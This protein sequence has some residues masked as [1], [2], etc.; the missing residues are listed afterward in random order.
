MGGREVRG[1]RF[2]LPVALLVCAWMVSLDSTALAQDALICRKRDR[3]AT[4][5][6]HVFHLG[7]GDDHF[8]AGPG[9]DIVYGGPGNDVVNGGRGNDVVHG[10][11]GNDIACGGVG[12][13]KVD[14]EAGRDEVYGEEGNDVIAGGPG[15]DYIAGQAGSDV[16]VGFGRHRGKPVAHG[17]D[18]L[19]GSYRPD[20]LK[21]GGADTAYGGEGTDL[22]KSETPRLG[23]RRLDGG[24]DE[25]VLIGSNANDALLFDNQSRTLFRARGG[26]DTV[27]GSGSADRIYGGSGDDD[28]LGLNGSDLIFGDE[29][30]DF[31]SGNYDATIDA[32]C[33]R[34]GPYSGSDRDEGQ[35]R[36]NAAVAALHAVESRPGK[37][38]VEALRKQLARAPRSGPDL[39]LSADFASSR[40]ERSRLLDQIDDAEWSLRVVHVILSGRR[41][42]HEGRAVIGAQ[43][44]FVVNGVTGDILCQP[45]RGLQA[46]GC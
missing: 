25:D 18:F 46:N 6:A 29:G 7:R 31:C 33:E 40:G 15:D 3:Q 35:G 27:V 1:I 39:H 37:P 20:I 13:D 8:N 42:R 4:G 32:S 11:P 16:L 23:L 2:A 44:I 19:E 22:L 36:L 24:P 5:E 21:V 30:D 43:A 34:G 17:R 14:G 28:L 10:G 45:V 26:D 12:R 9:P 41:P 38:R